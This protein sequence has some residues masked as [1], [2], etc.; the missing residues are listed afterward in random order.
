MLQWLEVENYR[1]LVRTRFEPGSLSLL[2]GANGS[3]KSS[4]FHG[5]DLLRQLLV[6]RTATVN[7]FPADST[8]RGRGETQ[9]KMRLALD[10]DGQ[11]F[12]YE[13]SVEHRSGEPEPHFKETLTVDDKP[14][15]DRSEGMARVFHDGPAQYERLLVDAVRSGIPAIVRNPRPGQVDISK[16]R[17]F[18]EAL[19]RIL[20]VRIA[21]LT[22][23]SRT[24]R[25]VT[26]PRSEFSDF[27]SWYRHL[28]LVQ[29]ETMQ[30]LFE[31]LASVIPG[32]VKLRL[33]EYPSNVRELRVELTS[34]G[35][36]KH[37]TF[38]EIS[39]GQRALI[40]L[41]TILHCA[42][43]KDSLILLDEP[44]NFMSLPEVQPWLVAFADRVCAVGAQAVVASHHPEVIDYLAG[45]GVLLAE[46]DAQGGTTVRPLTF[47]AS[48]G[49]KLSDALARGWIDG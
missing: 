45:S 34:H 13:M 5:L 22:M 36:T 38:E 29:P 31:D 46:A 35:S 8:T 24:D 41:Y 47:D 39:D 6:D 17:T 15:F 25:E 48:K 9:Q 43:T 4:L 7:L 21:P 23:T 49:L 1:S 14:V 3:G 40:A 10:L 44:D 20:L 27:A 12:L 30:A 18:S 16:I 11:R 42:V 19:S 32:F 33:Q 26:H 28:A 37:Y 2:I